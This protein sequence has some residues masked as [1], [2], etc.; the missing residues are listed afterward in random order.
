[1]QILL[2]MIGIAKLLSCLPYTF[3]LLI[4]SVDGLRIK[5]LRPN[6]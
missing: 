1:M 6:Y 4:T 3:N 5:L 2:L